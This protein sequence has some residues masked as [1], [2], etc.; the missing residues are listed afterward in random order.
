M[1][2]KNTIMLV[3]DH[4]IIRDGLKLYFEDSDEYDVVA[5]AEN[6]VQA[7]KMLESQEVD[8]VITDISM[9]EMDGI[10]FTQKLK[11]I[12]P[13]QKVMALTMMGENQHIKHM[14]SAG[15]NGYI[16]KNSDKSEIMKAIAT[17]LNGENFYSSEV[18]KII[19]D[20]MAG[21]RKPTQRLTLETPLTTREKEVLKL[22]VKE[23]SNQEIADALFISHR[24]VDAHKRNLLEKTGCKN[25]AGLVVYALEHNIE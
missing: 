15:V 3:D 6:G 5:E 19:M 10:T 11:E 24:T 21:K 9:P 7:L 17:I 25:I 14:L 22:I 18:T 20:S 23:Y 12:R 2:Q 13:D 8:L 1:A 16:L 4:K